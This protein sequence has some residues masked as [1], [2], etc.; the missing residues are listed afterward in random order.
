MSFHAHRTPLC[1]ILPRIMAEGQ[2]GAGHTRLQSVRPLEAE[3]ENVSN[4][5]MSASKKV[6]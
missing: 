3:I 4:G 6:G 1:Y 2:G 5:L